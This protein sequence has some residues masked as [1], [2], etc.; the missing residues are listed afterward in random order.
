MLFFA[1]AARSSSVPEV[2]AVIDPKII[3]MTAMMATRIS[4]ALTIFLMAPTMSDP[5][6]TPSKGERTVAKP[7]AWDIRGRA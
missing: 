4:R 1:R 2:A 7:W 6:W 3:A 5:P